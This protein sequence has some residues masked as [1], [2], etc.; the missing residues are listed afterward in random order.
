MSESIPGVPAETPVAT[1]QAAPGPATGT[2]PLEQ[3]APATAP[4]AVLPAAPEVTPTGTTS[5][6]AEAGKETVTSDAPGDTA[7]AAEVPAIEPQTNAEG[8]EKEPLPLPKYEDFTLPEDVKLE[9]AQM[10]A[11]QTILG[12]TENKIITT[13]AEAH[14]AVQ[15]MGQRM[16]DMYISESKAQT[17]RYAQLQ[18]ENWTRVREDWV[19]KFKADPEIGGNRRDTTIAHIGALV[20]LYGQRVGAEQ[21]Q[22]VRDAMT[23]TGAGDHPETL[24]FLS[25]AAS[26]AVERPR[27]VAAT[28]PPKAAPASKAARLYR[29]TIAGAA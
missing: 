12:E 14:A 5:V 28:Q 15:E 1:G 18:M 16:L 4:A 24:R 8:K 2:T 17:E 21:A 26:F 29:N 11:F 22:A 19:A 3:A 10:S 9:D 23:L 7:A 13:P 25:W 20:E 27:M 6:F